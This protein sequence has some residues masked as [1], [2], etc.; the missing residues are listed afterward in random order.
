MGILVRLQEDGS[1]AN[2]AN[3]ASS[4]IVASDKLSYKPA[5]QREQVK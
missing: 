4:T 3:E 2:E 5:E 1:K